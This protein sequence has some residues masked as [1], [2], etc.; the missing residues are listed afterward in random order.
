MIA[1]INTIPVIKINL[2]MIPVFI[3]DVLNRMQPFR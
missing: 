1:P 2:F 3:F